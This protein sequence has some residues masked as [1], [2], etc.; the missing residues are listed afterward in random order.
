ML[1]FDSQNAEFGQ[2]CAG[3]RSHGSVGCRNFACELSASTTERACYYWA[4]TVSPQI[5]GELKPAA[6]ATG[7]SDGL[8]IQRGQPLLDGV[9]GEPGNVLDAKFF[10]DVFAVS[11]NG[12]RAQA[13]ALSNLFGAMAFR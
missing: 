12:L 13:E 7:E 6:L 5:G 9:F 2:R 11:G 1:S 10:H 4:R 8:K 3:R